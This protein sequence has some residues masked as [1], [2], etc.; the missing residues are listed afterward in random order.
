MSSDEEEEE[1]FIQQGKDQ[2]SFNLIDA[3]N[4][5]TV[6]RR[7]SL[8]HE[9]ACVFTL[10]KKRVNFGK[11]KGG[12]VYKLEEEEKIPNIKDHTQNTMILSNA[13]YKDNPAAY[14]EEASMNHTIHTV[15]AVSQNSPQ[16]RGG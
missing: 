2:E 8:S 11:L 15:A 5:K 9:P 13:V 16:N 6:Q 3:N 14:L 12:R 4:A 1:V 10:T 7:F